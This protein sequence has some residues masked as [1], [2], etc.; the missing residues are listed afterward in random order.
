MKKILLSL[1]VVAAASAV[2]IGATTAFFSDTETSTGNVFTAGAIDLKVDSDC[3]YYNFVGDVPG[4]DEDGYVDVGCGTWVPDL[5]PNV[6][7]VPVAVGSWSE[8]DLGQIHRFFNFSDIKPGDKGEDTI[9]LHVY[10]ND[11]WGKISM[12]LGDDLDNS[13]TEPELDAEP[14]C[15]GDLSIGELLGAMLPGFSMWLDQGSTP[16]FQNIG[17]NG[18]QIDGNGTEA[19]NPL[20]DPT[21]G[22]N[23]WQQ[24]EG[25]TWNLSGEQE[26]SEVLSAAYSA[27]ICNDVDVN[28]VPLYNAD[29]HNN[30]ETCNGLAADGRMVGSTTY[31]FGLNWELPL[32]I[33]NE[34]QTDSLSGDLSFEVE[35]HRNNPN[36]WDE[37]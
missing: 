18:V 23:V 6:T 28:N 20:V 12:D 25:N 32:N 27:G 1:V 26:L 5:G 13:C 33:G 14:L 34:V 31:Y 35:Q 10:D 11:A 16:G 30:Y 4:A 21:E 9:S 8:N 3:H 17:A 15:A 29:G 7:P 36:P 2:V 24:E 19:G 22:D 37:D